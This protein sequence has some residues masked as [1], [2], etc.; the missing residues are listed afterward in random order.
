MDFIEALPKSEGYTVI[1]V[2]VDRF[3]KYA[4]FIPLKHPFSAPV[5]AKAFLHTLVNLHGPPHTIVSDR[6]KIFTSHFWRDLFKLWDTKLLMSTAYHP[7]TDGQSERVNRCLEM[8]LR[9]AVHDT[10][11][12]WHAWLPLAEFWYNTNYHSSLECSPFKALYGYEPTYGVFPSLLQSDNIDVAQWLQEHQAHIV[13]LKAHLFKAQAKM[14]HYADKNRTPRM[15]SV[16]DEVF[17]KLQPY[18]H[19]T[20]ANRPC[21]KLSYK[22]YGPFPIVEQIGPAAYRLQ[23]PPATQIHPV[24]HVSQLKEFVPDHTPVFSILPAP[25]DLSSRDVQPGAILE[26]KLVKKGN[27][28]LLQV[29]I[30]WTGLPAE[31]ATWENYDTLKLRYPTAPAWGQS[32]AQEGGNVSTSALLLIRDVPMTVQTKL[33]DTEWVKRHEDKSRGD[34]PLGQVERLGL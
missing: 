16:G 17:L 23:L 19:T 13:V 28:A 3:T 27:T 5:V 34:G 22:F 7:Q 14:K 11:T 21:A 20:V 24:F 8:F 6:D 12:K 25:V 10:P 31:A 2:V 1:L 4:H 32:E 15:F 9:C 30:Q 29:L 18:A 26:R 33:I